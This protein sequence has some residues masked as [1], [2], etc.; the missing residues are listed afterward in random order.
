MSVLTCDTAMDKQKAGISS[1]EL[2]K[3][4]TQM[5]WQKIPQLGREK[6][7]NEGDNL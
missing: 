3:L 6:W 2:N 1:R 5:T 4:L 7:G